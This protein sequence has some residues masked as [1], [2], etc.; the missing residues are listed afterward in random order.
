ML[1]ANASSDSMSLLNPTLSE[2]LEEFF[3]L[4]RFLRKGIIGRHENEINFMR[5]LTVLILT[6]WSCSSG[7]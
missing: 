2:I 4:Q 3:S 5:S 6:V 7:E 1:N